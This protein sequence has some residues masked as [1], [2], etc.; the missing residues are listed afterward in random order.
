MGAVSQSY[1]SQEMNIACLGWG[2][3]IW[4][5][6]DLKVVSW[7]TDGPSLPLEFARV[8]QDGRLTLVL[9]SEGHRLPVLYG[10]VDASDLQTAVNALAR[11]EGCSVQ[12]IGAWKREGPPG[13]G[14]VQSVAAWAEQREGIDAVV[15]TALGPRFAETDGRI[16][17]GEEAVDYLKSLKGQA[18]ARAEEYVRR[19]PKQIRTPYRKLFESELGWG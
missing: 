10:H 7:H 11:R 17:A 3:L 2:S 1:S 18:K 13:G 5:P 19:A 14:N 16:P 4:D 6:R 8:S 9:L 15:W 12:R